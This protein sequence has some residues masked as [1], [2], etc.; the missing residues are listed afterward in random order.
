MELVGKYTA[1]EDG[2]V[3]IEHEIGE[4]ALKSSQ[5]TSSIQSVLK[6]Y[7]HLYLSLQKAEL[8]NNLTGEAGAREFCYKIIASAT[9]G[10]TSGPLQELI[11]RIT[12]CENILLKHKEKAGKSLALKTPTFTDADLKKYAG[13]DAEALRKLKLPPSMIKESKEMAVL[14]AS[15]SVMKKD[16]TTDLDARSLAIGAVKGDGNC[17]FRAISSARKGNDCSNGGQNDYADLRN[18]AS[19]QMQ[20][21]IKL[22]EKDLETHLALTERGADFDK[23]TITIESEIAFLKERKTIASR[24][25]EFAETPEIEA[26]SHA[27]KVPFTILSWHGDKTG[28]YP[29]P[30]GGSRIHSHQINHDL[31]TETQAITLAHQINHYDLVVPKD[32]A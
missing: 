15:F 13:F 7:E 4:N 2:I 6:N 9:E 30:E 11:S 20:L 10:A 17:F 16:F 23:A 5:L 28:P 26:L 1:L 12:K 8:K 25:T 18:K 32:A 3:A 27:L 22:L 31:Y 19:L 14:A 24:D 21:N 29:I